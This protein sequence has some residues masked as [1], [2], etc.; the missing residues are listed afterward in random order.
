MPRRSPT[1][2]VRCQ[3]CAS[4]IA[5]AC[6]RQARRASI[7]AARACGLDLLV[8]GSYQRAGDRL[9]IT[10]RA[11]HAGSGEAVAHSKADGAV[12]DVFQLQ[13][14]IVTQL[15]R[16]L[17]VPVTA[18]AAAS[19]GVHETSSLEAYRALTEGRLKLETLNPADVPA[20]HSRL[21]ACHRAGSALRPRV[22]RPGTRAPVAL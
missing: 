3:I 16:S 10:A 8:V 5:R 17:H 21:R 4:S 1:I 22:C 19:I 7:E 14:A 13:D 9:R 18:A 20:G 6:R 15:L 2:Y 12:T 11:I